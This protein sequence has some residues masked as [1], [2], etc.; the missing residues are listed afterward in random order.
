MVKKENNY[1]LKSAAI[2]TV[3]VLISIFG[4]M[5]ANNFM[6]TKRFGGGFMP[7]PEFLFLG[8][9]SYVLSTLCL[10]LSVYL[11]FIYIKDYLELRS[12]FTLSIVFSLVALMLFSLTSNPMVHSMFGFNANRADIFSFVPLFFTTIA[13]AILAWVSSK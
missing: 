12:S 4:L 1:A 2:T 13:L 6:L 11:M 7:P 3:V 5:F 10:G 9:L 8:I